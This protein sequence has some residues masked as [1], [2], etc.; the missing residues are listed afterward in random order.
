[1][2]QEGKTM[3]K[4]R[5]TEVETTTLLDALE[6]AVQYRTLLASTARRDAATSAHHGQAAARYQ[7]LLDATEPVTI[8]RIT[9]RY[10]WGRK[11]GAWQVR[12]ED[13]TLHGVYAEW[14]DANEAVDAIV[15]ES[16]EV[17]SMS[18]VHT[19]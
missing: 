17:V 13:G 3:P 10:T 16:D 18:Y 5:L 12:R 19:P 2:K 14:I 7:D 15:A 9:V 1:V 11:P 4:Y 8:D 6:D